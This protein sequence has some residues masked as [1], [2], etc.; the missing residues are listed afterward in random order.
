MQRALARTHSDGGAVKQR[1]HLNQLLLLSVP[2]A[3]LNG[4]AHIQR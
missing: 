1:A 2:H 4:G 3:V